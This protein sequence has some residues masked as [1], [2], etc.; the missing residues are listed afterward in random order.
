MPAHT[1]HAHTHTQTYRPT[2]AT[3]SRPQQLFNSSSVHIHEAIIAHHTYVS[4]S[5]LCG[6][7]VQRV[8]V[9]YRY[10][11][12]IGGNYLADSGVWPRPLGEGEGGEGRGRGWTGGDRD[13]HRTWSG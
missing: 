2:I 10:I 13:G 8:A 3:H 12:L 4:Y 9:N 11:Q 6:S 7:S 1:E 5:Y